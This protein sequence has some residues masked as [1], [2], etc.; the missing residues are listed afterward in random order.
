MPQRST[1]TYKGVSNL[2]SPNM[3]DIAQ[4][5]NWLRNAKAM[6]ILTGAGMGV[7]SGLADYRG[8]GGQWGRVEDSTGLNAIDVLNPKYFSE[9]TKYV[10]KMFA[11]RMLEY[12]HT[13]PHNGFNILKKW[14]KDFKLDYFVISSNVD[15]HF[16]KS[17]FD[18]NKYRELHGSLF[19]MQCSKPCSPKVWYYDFDIENLM[20][21][22]E[23]E[24]YPKCPYCSELARP[25]VYMFR[26]NTYILSRSEQQKKKF[27]LFLD[28]NKGHEIIV[29]EIG[30]GPHVQ[31][32][33]KKTRRLGIDYNAKIV[34][35]NPKDFKIKAPHIGISKGA[36][37]ALSEIDIFIN[38]NK[39]R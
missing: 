4:I 25:N 11:Q 33:R 17:G 7:D 6:I 32:I 8:D 2:N 26:D 13:V 36:L 14:I 12:K 23:E 20:L 35:I 9:H 39:D 5:Y 27:Q 18:E 15:E 29:F 16:I 21:D 31:S 30:S 37:E 38:N 34:R 1:R 22:I 28:Q 3:N 19:Y 24:N 10:W